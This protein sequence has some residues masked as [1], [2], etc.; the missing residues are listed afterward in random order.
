MNTQELQKKIE[1]LEIACAAS[2]SFIENLRVPQDKLQAFFQLRSANRVVD[3][4]KNA[5]EKPLV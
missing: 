4:L 1:Q 3:Q 2:L 5:L